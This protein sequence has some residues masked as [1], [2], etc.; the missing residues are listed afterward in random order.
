[1]LLKRTGQ[2][3]P[4]ECHFEPD[5]DLK[6][7]TIGTGVAQRLLDIYGEAPYGVMDDFNLLPLW[8]NS[9]GSVFDPRW[10]SWKAD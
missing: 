6:A 1:M 5:R 9:F 3:F 4:P 10:V 7:Q 2:G 8:L